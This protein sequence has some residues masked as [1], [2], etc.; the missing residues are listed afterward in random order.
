MAFPGPKVH[1]VNRRKLGRH[2]VPS[3][4]PITFVFS[5]SGAAA[6]V[7]VYTVTSSVPVVVTG[8][9][10]FTTST[11]GTVASQTIISP[12]QLAV[13]FSA[14]TASTAT[15]ALVAAPATVAGYQGNVA[16]GVT[17]GTI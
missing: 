9:I 7:A 3:V 6:T 5:P 15:W 11:P 10:P 17:G 2:Q 16:A 1:R 4:P 8:L 14:A 13:T 12:T